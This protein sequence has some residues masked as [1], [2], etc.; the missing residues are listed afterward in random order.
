MKLRIYLPLM[1][2]FDLVVA[3]L[4]P[5]N[6]GSL[7]IFALGCF[8]LGDWF[9]LACNASLDQKKMQIIAMQRE[10]IRL[11]TDIILKEK[12]HEHTN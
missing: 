2:G 8:V 11:S 7:L 6:Y 5:F 12:A 3:A 4:P 10:L 9:A 1:A